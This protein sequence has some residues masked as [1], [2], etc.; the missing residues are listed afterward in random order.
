MHPFL[1]DLSTLSI[2]SACPLDRRKIL[3]EIVSPGFSRIKRN[4]SFV[5]LI[6]LNGRWKMFKLL[7]LQAK[8][9]P[10][11]RFER[12]RLARAF[13]ALEKLSNRL[14]N[15]LRNRR[16]LPRVIR[17]HRYVT[18]ALQKRVYIPAVVKR[19]DYGGWVTEDW[20]LVYW[21][22]R[23][24]MALV[25]VSSLVSLLYRRLKA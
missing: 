21:S 8:S 20:R 3:A 11:F 22:W 23:R 17:G 6:K 12:K 18:A 13:L 7:S 14:R 5:R 4:H 2:R 16:G 9:S 24:C 15:R 19:R 1:G 25:M 10:R